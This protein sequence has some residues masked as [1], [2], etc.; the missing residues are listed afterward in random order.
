[1]PYSRSA[2]VDIW[3][4]V[5]GSGPALVLVHANPFDHDLWLYQAAHFST[6]FTVVGIDIRGYGR[7]SKVTEPY[8]L[9]AMSDD[10]VGVMRDLG[11]ARAIL[12][13]CSVGSGIAILSALDHAEL[14]EAVVLVGGNSAASSRYQRRIEGYRADL[15]AYHVCHMRELVSQSFAESRLGSHLLNMWVEREPRLEGEAIA[16][17]FAAGNSTDTTKRLPTMK[18]PTLVING[19]YDHSLPAGRRT[20]S[21]IPGAAHKVLPG[22]GHACC[23]EDPAGFDALVI[24]FLRSRGLMPAI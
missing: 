11:I 24:D 4:E 10:V 16:Q 3:Y 1:M 5:N 14:F 6:W 9:K 23:I 2:G 20:A 15:G 18:V 12:M 22:T 7:S 13:G 19:E 21:L 17:V 8:S